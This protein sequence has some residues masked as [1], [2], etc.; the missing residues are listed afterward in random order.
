M[1]AWLF[2]IFTVAMIGCLHS[3]V[4]PNKIRISGMFLSSLELWSVHYPPLDMTHAFEVKVQRHVLTSSLSLPQVIVREQEDSFE[5]SDL[6]GKDTVLSD[7]NC[8][9]VAK[10][11]DSWYLSKVLLKSQSLSLQTCSTL[12][13]SLHL[14]SLN[15]WEGREQYLET[16]KQKYTT[17]SARSTMQTWKQ[18]SNHPLSVILL[19]KEEHFTPHFQEVLN[20]TKCKL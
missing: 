9:H 2:I 12:K 17:W 11:Q 10:E 6:V 14:N 3:T 4:F 15:L 5:H 18:I 20:C 19:L 1:G 16:H 8:G 13:R 7:T